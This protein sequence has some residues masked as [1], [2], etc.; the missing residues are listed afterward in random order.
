MPTATIDHATLIK[1]TE[2]DVVR[3]VQVIGQPAGRAV[4]IQY[5]M[6]ETMLA[7]QRSQMVRLFCKPIPCPCSSQ[8]DLTTFEHVEIEAFAFFL[9]WSKF[10]APE[11]IT[12]IE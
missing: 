5:G 11:I 10:P 2:T 12:R 9:K 3:H 7:A 4:L 1:L 6:T 8:K